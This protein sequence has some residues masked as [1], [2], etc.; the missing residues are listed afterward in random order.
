MGETIDEVQATLE[1]CSDDVCV[2]VRENADVRE[3]LVQQA[4]GHVE[5]GE[6]DDAAAAV[7]EVRDIVE[8]D[9]ERLENGN[10]SPIYEGEEV[11]GENALNRDSLVP[12]GNDPLT[13]AERAELVE[14]L[15]GSPMVGERF[16]VCLPDAEVPGGNGSLVEEVT[17]QRFIDYITGRSDSEGKLYAWGDGRTVAGDDD[18]DD[19]DECSESVGSG[20]NEILCKSST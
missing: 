8:G 14:Y 4:Q 2:T 7:D 5:N 9:I 19:D 3:K 15:S 1:R 17:P 10:G 16:I 11:G 6:W 13:D 20:S 18:D 12:P